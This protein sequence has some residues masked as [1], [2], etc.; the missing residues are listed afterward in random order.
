MVPQLAFAPQAVIG[1]NTPGDINFGV[2]NFKSLAAA[3]LEPRRLTLLA[4]ANSSGKSSFLQALLFLA[5]SNGQATPV[6]NGDLVRLGEPSDVLRDGTDSLT[7]EFSY[8]PVAADGIDES[9]GE[10]QTLRIALDK[11]KDRPTLTVAEISLWHNGGCTASATRQPQIPGAP[12]LRANETALVQAQPYEDLIIVIS[13]ITPTRILYRVTRES[14]EVAVYPL[15]RETGRGRLNILAQLLVQAQVE[16]A[17]EVVTDMTT[18]RERFNANE[19]VEPD[20]PLLSKV[21]D[22]FVDYVAPGNWMVQPVLSPEFARFGPALLI[23]ASEAPE[24]PLALAS[25]LGTA[26]ERVSRLASAIVYLGPLRD[27]PR[28]AYPLGHTID[29]LPVGEK[30]EFTAAFVLAHGSDTLVYGNPDGAMRRSSFRAALVEWCKHLEIAQ[31]VAVKE[32]GKLGHQLRLRVGG[33]QRDPTAIGVGASQLL[34]VVAVVLGAPAGSLVL[35]EQPEL[36]LHPRVQSRLGDFLITARPD[37]RIVVE[38]H[39]EYLVTRLRL[40][41]AQGTLLASDVAVLFASVRSSK[42]GAEDQY[43]D[44]AALNL[45]QLGD[46]DYWPPAFF[47]SLDVDNVALADAVSA[48]LKAEAQ[49][50]DAP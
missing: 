28:V 32:M 29:A 50:D 5:Q 27:D 10:I 8:G 41:I 1:P 6:I 33:R 24:A 13:G 2:L 9:S 23:Q 12:P 48:R 31:D 21:M 26:V 20:D 47:D 38:T 15:L 37:I 34:P 36:H 11:P 49:S 14:A 25:E 22:R 4:G 43:T 18:L 16:E 44:F 42:E 45:D 30:G 7:L 39:S 19:V 17:D 35:L 40:R 46:L 3:K